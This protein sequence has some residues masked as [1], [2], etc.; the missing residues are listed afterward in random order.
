MKLIR[1]GNG[2]GTWKEGRI[3]FHSNPLS[4]SQTGLDTHY[5]ILSVFSEIAI[6]LMKLQGILKQF[7]TQI[8]ISC[9]KLKMAQTLEVFHCL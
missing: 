2:D 8:Q 3:S 4:V 5:K 9:S 7:Q 1:K 6:D